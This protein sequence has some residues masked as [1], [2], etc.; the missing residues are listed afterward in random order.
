MRV[1]WLFCA[2]SAALAAPAGAVSVLGDPAA[3]LRAMEELNLIVFADLDAQ[4]QEVEGKS[5]VGGN[6]AG[7]GTNWGI[8]N[9]RQGSRPSSRPTLSVVGDMRQQ[10]SQLNNGRN[11][12]EAQ[13]GTPPGLTVGGS[14]S[15]L[16]VNAANAQVVVGGNLANFNGANGGRVQ[17]GE[18]T[19]GNVN[20]NGSMI[21]TGLGT[22]FADSVL[23]GLQMERD[24][25]Q[26]NLHALSQTL[27]R[28]T[29]PDNPSSILMGAQGPL[30]Q[31]TGGDNG[32][33]VFTI[34]AAVLGRGEINFRL[35][36]GPVP[37]V[38]N[39]LGETVTWNANP[40]GGYNASL[41]PFIIWNF[42][43]ATEISTNR[44]VHGSILAPLA[45][46]TNTTPIEG[47]VVARE[48]S[49][50]GEVHL[51]SYAG[52]SNWLVEPVPEPMSWAMLIAGFGMVGAA[53]R[54]RRQMATLALSRP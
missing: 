30:F 36:D 18:R 3:G 20:A 38:I 15:G 2:L 47:T 41:N 7:N 35:M 25:L 44:M 46:L 49:M 17:V 52:G 42:V 11:G 19:Q 54:R 23:L 13:I 28:L 6:V 51:G 33:A 29:L 16:N 26:T 22:A 53:M 8:G 40:V 1:L 37:I 5:F 43:Q 21:T 31:V 50:R 24:A 39:V 9:P 32:F 12:A 14:V 10:N 34:D 27:A 45:R 48:M 4:G